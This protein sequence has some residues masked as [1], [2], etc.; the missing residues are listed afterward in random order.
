MSTP[1]TRPGN[2]A[3]PAGVHD[4]V[5]S[6]VAAVRAR[7]DDLSP[8]EVEELTDGLE[9]DLTEALAGFDETPRQRFGDPAAYADE[10]RAAADLPPRRE[11]P[12]PSGLGS[13]LADTRRQV[14]ASFDDQLEALRRFP[15]YAPTRD[16]LVVVRPAWWVLRAWVA[17]TA[18]RQMTGAESSGVIGGFGSLVVLLLAIVASVTIGR[19]SPLRRTAAR[20]AVVVGNVLAVVALPFVVSN[21]SQEPAYV[22]TGVQQGLW[23]DGT[24]ITNILPYDSQGRSLTGVQLYDADGQPIRIPDWWSDEPLRGPSNVYPRPIPSDDLAQPDVPVLQPTADPSESAAAPEPTGS[25]SDGPSAEVTEEP[26]V[27]PT[28]SA[29]ATS[30]GVAP[31]PA[32]TVTPSP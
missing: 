28:A 13:A 21:V 12:P 14:L 18:L 31:T 10:L 4:D 2:G 15:W 6:Y 23:M 22:E 20:T 11:P 32:A 1:T 17:V 7:L 3:V 29:S 30:R 9:A 8:E 16:F 25:P 19:R 27:E 24:E 5:P 26:T